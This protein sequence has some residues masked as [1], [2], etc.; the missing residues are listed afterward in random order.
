MQLVAVK[1]TS[2]GRITEPVPM[3]R[4]RRCRADPYGYNKD[5]LF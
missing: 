2:P 1:A 5:E 4:C 3:F